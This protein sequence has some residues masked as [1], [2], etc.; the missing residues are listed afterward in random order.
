MAPKGA[1]REFLCPYLTAHPYPGWLKHGQLACIVVFV[2][3]DSYWDPAATPTSLL[4]SIGLRP[5]NIILIRLSRYHTI[6]FF[7]LTHKF[8]DR[9]TFLITIIEH[10]IFQPSKEPFAGCIVSRTSFLGHRSGES[11]LIHTFYPHWP[12]IVTSAV[13]VGYRGCILRKRLYCPVKHNID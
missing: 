10:L 3:A 5:H 9:H 2:G 8:S 12:A 11:R 4:C 1:P 7:E 13:C 6:I